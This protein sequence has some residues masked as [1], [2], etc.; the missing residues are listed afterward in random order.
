MKY[1]VIILAA[2][3]GSR[4]GLNYNKILY[5]IN[6]K[7]VIDYS[8]NFFENDLDCSQIILVVNPQ[9]ISAFSIG[10]NSKISNIIFGGKTRQESVRNSLKYID[11]NYVLIHDSARPFIPIES[12]ENMKE[13]LL[14]KSSLTL[15]VP[16]TDTIQKVAYGFVTETIDRKPL[17]ATQTP[18]AFHRD[19]LVKAHFM[20]FEQN[21]EATD[22]TT[23]LLGMLD[24]KAFVVPGDQRNI[25]FTNISDAKFLEVV[26]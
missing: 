17:I 4:T 8:L 23:L 18:Q 21:F 14:D 26:L 22:D 12:I 5:K 13:Y 2:G 25:K 10:N 6:G 15:G 3:S 16:V 7:R 9:D 20:A 24:I 11:E 19:V 1:S